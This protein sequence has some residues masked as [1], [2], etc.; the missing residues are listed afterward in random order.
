M[1]YDLYLE[2]KKTS[3]SETKVTAQFVMSYISC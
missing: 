2:E 1:Y 3:E